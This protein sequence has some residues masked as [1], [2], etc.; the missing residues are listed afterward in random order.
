MKYLVLLIFTFITTLGISQDTGMIVGKILDSE[1]DNQPLPFASVTLKG[2]SIASNSDITGLFLFENL[3][4]GEYTLVFNYPGY[5]SK[6]VNLQVNALEPTEI[7]LS[8]GQQTMTLTDV[9][10]L[11]NNIS[12]ESLSSSTKYT[13]Q[14]D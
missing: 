6:E 3:K 2:S 11:Q 14:E 13:P 1:L 9:A 4:D 12:D 7:K 10:L 8:L 5:Q